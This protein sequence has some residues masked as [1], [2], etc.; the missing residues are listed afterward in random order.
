[1]N[2]PTIIRD[3]AN[4][5][6]IRGYTAALIDIEHHLPNTIHDLSYSHKKPSEKFI[7][8]FMQVYID[9]RATLREGRGFIRVHRPDGM[10]EWFE[11]VK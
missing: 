3:P 2:A 8:E 1:M 11:G 5:D 6:W 4:G 9:N 7:K 10:L